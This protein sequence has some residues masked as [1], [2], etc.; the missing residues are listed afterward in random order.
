MSTVSPNSARES[1]VI[2]LRDQS[3]GG[4]ERRL[5]L[6]LLANFLRLLSETDLTRIQAVVCYNEA[7]K[8]MLAGSPVF[9]HLKR[10][11][12]AGVPLIA[13]RTC[14]EYFDI[15]E[16]LAVGRAG[17]M[18]EIQALMLGARVVAL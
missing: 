6:A 15:E 7:V 4:S 8:L 18:A 17:T 16:Q 1:I 14:L 13:C 2:A 3:M 5:G 12:E 10:L 9:A 11:A